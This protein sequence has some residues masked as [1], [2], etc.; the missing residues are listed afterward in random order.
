MKNRNIT[1]SY[2]EEKLKALKRYLLRKDLNLEEELRRTVEK[3]YVRHVPSAV[4]DYIEVSQGAAI[5]PST[6]Q[7]K[8]VEEELPG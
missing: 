7:H 1:V 3:L 2:D 4:Q 5:S 6:K 8:T